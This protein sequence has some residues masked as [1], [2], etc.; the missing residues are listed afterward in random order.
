MKNIAEF[1]QQCICHLVLFPVNSSDCLSFQ[2][3]PS[4]YYISWL[5]TQMLFLISNTMFWGNLGISKISVLPSEY[6]SCIW[7]GV[8]FYC[9]TLTVSCAVNLVWLMT[10]A[11]LSHWPSTFLCNCNMMRITKCCMVYVC[12]MNSYTVIQQLANWLVEDRLI[13]SPIPDAAVQY[14]SSLVDT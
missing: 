7:T 11:I 14:L 8:R 1:W 3:N 9:G 4:E 2:I 10:T 13:R 12:Q 5:F 6:V